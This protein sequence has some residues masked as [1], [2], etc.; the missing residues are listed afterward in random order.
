MKRTLVVIAILLLSSRVAAAQK[1]P[2]IPYADRVR[3]AEAFRIGD[4]LGDRVWA[5]WDAAPFAVLLVTSEYEFL[6]RHPHPSDDFHLTGYDSLLQSNVYVRKRTYATNLLA[7]FPAV[8]GISTIV[9]GQAEN[10]M[11]KTS[12]PWVVTVLHEHF[13]QLQ[14][15]QPDYYAAV[16]SLKLAHG[17][18][19]GMWMLNFDF[20]YASSDVDRQLALMG[21]LLA[22]ALRADSTSDLAADVAAY[23]DARWRFQKMISPDDYRYFSFQVWQEGMARYTEYRVAE[24]AARDCR[25]SGNFRA[26]KDY[27]P[28]AKVAADIRSRVMHELADLRLADEKR[29]AFYSVGAGEGFLLDKVRPGWQTRYFADKFHVDAYFDAT[30]R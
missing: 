20:P 9:I 21:R 17:D 14:S 23:L 18:K 2:A 10:T 7:T 3:L 8:G 25:P 6:V 15:S 13:H 16:D 4:T 26:L 22:K 27:E 19:T 12:T 24:L 5:G 1:E 30:P 11:K 29:V 28:F